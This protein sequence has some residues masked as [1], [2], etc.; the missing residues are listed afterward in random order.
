[1]QDEVAE[2]DRHDRDEVGDQRADLLGNKLNEA[3]A[4]LSP[5]VLALG[6]ARIDAALAADP[7]LAIYRFPLDR[8]LRAAPH[9]LDAEGEAL[10]AG[11]GQMNDAGQSVYTILTNAD[12]PWPGDRSCQ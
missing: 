10:V 4:F 2:R 6:K 9:T 7:A 12:M 11:F 8:I 5:E 1:M 3:D